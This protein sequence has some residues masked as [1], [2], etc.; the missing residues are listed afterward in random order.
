MVPADRRV[1]PDTLTPGSLVPY[2]GHVLKKFDKRA[3]QNH[4]SYDGGLIR[5]NIYS[6]AFREWFPLPMEEVSK[7]AATTGGVDG[8]HGDEIACVPPNVIEVLASLEPRRKV[9][10]ELDVPRGP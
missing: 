9:T 8:W 1:L 3:W 6:A 4:R 10:N 5:R 7:A 2:L